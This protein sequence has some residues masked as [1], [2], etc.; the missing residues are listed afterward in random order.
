[1]PAKSTEIG[2]FEWFKARCLSGDCDLGLID[3]YVKSEQREH[4]RGKVI[5]TC[6][7]RLENAGKKWNSWAVTNC[8]ECPKMPI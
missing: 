7:V 4:M 5:G 2:T 6:A 3:V 8:K 1:M